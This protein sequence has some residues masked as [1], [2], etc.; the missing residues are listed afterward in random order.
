MHIMIQLTHMNV[1]P[2]MVGIFTI[3]AFILS[4]TPAYATISC[5][6]YLPSSYFERIENNKQ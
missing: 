1:R 6:G 2:M 5:A 4:F 3:I